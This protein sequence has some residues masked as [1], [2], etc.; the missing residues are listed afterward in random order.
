MV[1]RPGTYETIPG[2]DLSDIL[3]FALG[4][5]G[6]ANTNKITLDKLDLESS[7]IIKIITNNTA[8]SLKD[9]LSVKFFHIKTTTHLN[10]YVNGAVEEPGYYKLEDYESL[11]D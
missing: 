9:V 3:K 2:E 11:E 1:K 6:G 7:S 10:V 5:S 8:H 4:F